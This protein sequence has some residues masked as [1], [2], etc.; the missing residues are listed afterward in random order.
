M[1]EQKYNIE[2]ACPICFLDIWNTALSRVDNKTKICK[3]CGLAE[4]K[5]PIGVETTQEEM[6]RKGHTDYGCYLKENKG[7]DHE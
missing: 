3:F 4:G 7:E 5:D 1:M 2:T 6:V